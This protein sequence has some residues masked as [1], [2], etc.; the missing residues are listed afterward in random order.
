MNNDKR[1]MR[2]LEERLYGKK[3]KSQKQ[4]MIKKI[5]EK[6]PLTRQSKQALK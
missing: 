6:T 4:I 5:L 3:Y 2:I 1:M